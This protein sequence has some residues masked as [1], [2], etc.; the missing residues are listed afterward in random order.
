MGRRWTI[1]RRQGSNAGWMTKIG[2]KKKTKVSSIS[3]MSRKENYKNSYL[4]LISN[5]MLSMSSLRM[6]W[7]SGGR[8]RYNR[9]K[10]KGRII[11]EVPIKLT[12]KHR[13]RIRFHRVVKD[14]EK[15][16]K[17]WSKA[18]ERTLIM[19]NGQ[20][21][22]LVRWLETNF[23]IQISHWP[24]LERKVKVMQ[25]IA[26]LTIC[27]IM[28]VILIKKG[29]FYQKWKFGPAFSKGLITGFGIKE[30][31]KCFKNRLMHQAWSKMG[32]LF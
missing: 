10:W 13:K 3:I 30:T 31:N 14:V 22:F 7:G 18:Q 19:K 1:A 24:T 29:T 32:A 23:W 26:I 8:K 28:F 5:R 11:K 6:T 17:G 27:I 25:N 21:K 4:K 16:T 15:K 2:M 12:I 20:A 9:N